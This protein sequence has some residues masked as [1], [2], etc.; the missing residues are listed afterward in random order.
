MPE[1]ELPKR[2]GSWDGLP[3]QCVSPDSCPTTVVSGADGSVMVCPGSAD[4]PPALVEALL[5]R[6][7]VGEAEALREL[8]L[9]ALV[10]A[11]ERAE[12][13]SPT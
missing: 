4:G 1:R 3:I 2:D 13:D 8:L 10:K 11:P 9:A 12:A 5:R 6:L 7:S